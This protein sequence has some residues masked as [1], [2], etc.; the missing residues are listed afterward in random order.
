MALSDDAKRATEWA[1]LVPGV[2]RVL[3]ELADSEDLRAAADVVGRVPVG[4]IAEA[5]ARYRHDTATIEKGSQVVDPG[6]QIAV[7]EDGE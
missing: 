1:T 3:G 6:V 7:A 4:T 2:L 5:L